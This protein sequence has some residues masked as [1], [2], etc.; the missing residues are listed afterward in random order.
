MSPSWCVRNWI[1]FVNTQTEAF[2]SNKFVW[3]IIDPHQIVPNFVLS[4]FSSE[5]R[6]WRRLGERGQRRWF[7]ISSTRS[8]EQTI[9]SFFLL[10]LPPL[11]FS[12]SLKQSVHPHSV[13][14]VS[15]N[16][17]SKFSTH[18]FAL[19][20]KC[21]HLSLQYRELVVF[22]WESSKSVDILW[23][24][25]FYYWCS[26]KTRG[27]VKI[28]ITAPYL[29]HPVLSHLFVKDVQILMQIIDVTI[30]IHYAQVYNCIW[31]WTAVQKYYNCK[32]NCVCIT[33]R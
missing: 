30:Q 7:A 2:K 5:A 24:Q 25:A 27:R 20:G 1:L 23:I 26:E 31:I 17:G 28:F 12:Y 29:G 15:V 21:F 4:L 9:P 22:V 3:S 33:V 10:C 16:I 19:S 13:N 11:L 32:N 8:S 14:H 18:I 6:R